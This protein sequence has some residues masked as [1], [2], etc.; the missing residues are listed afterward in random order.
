MNKQIDT[1]FELFSGR[2][3]PSRIYNGPMKYNLVWANGGSKDTR[4]IGKSGPVS[5]V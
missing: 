3:F 4:S 2:D 5:D 1:L